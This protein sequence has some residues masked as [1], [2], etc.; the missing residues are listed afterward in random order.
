M[1]SGMHSHALQ[2]LVSQERKESLVARHRA[3]VKTGMSCAVVNAQ[4]LKLLTWNRPPS[5]APPIPKTVTSRPVLPSFL[6]GIPA[7]GMF[8]LIVNKLCA[9]SDGKSRVTVYEKL[10]VAFV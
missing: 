3:D 10:E 5:G 2:S 1:Q 4:V 7:G 9:L 8:E 6:F